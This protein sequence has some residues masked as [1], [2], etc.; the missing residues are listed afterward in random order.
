MY[1]PSHRH[2]GSWRPRE[3]AGNSIGQFPRTEFGRHPDSSPLPTQPRPL[4]LRLLGE[5]NTSMY[6]MI[7][8]GDP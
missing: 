7:H 1:C 6:E 8:V 5:Q 2:R 3:T 4:K